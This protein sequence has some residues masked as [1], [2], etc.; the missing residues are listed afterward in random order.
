MEWISQVEF[1]HWWILA[2]A[3]I[4]LELFAP[5]AFF[6]WIGISAAVVGGL[7]WLLPNTTWETQ[8][9]VFAVLS[10]V[11]VVGWRIYLR[12]HPIQTD[13]PVLNRRGHHYVGRVFTLEQPIING[14]G[15]IRVDD[16]IWKVQGA[17]LPAGAKI[18]VVGVDGVVL[19]VVPATTV[20]SSL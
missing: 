15:K 11:S 4:V 14:S 3:L 1:W 18:Q 17:D 10:I 19:Q 9:V 16:S 13:R 8:L 20:S 5:G 6:L 12:R 7:L 2:A